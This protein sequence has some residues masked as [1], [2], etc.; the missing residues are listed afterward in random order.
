[1]C[2]I[3]SGTMTLPFLKAPDVLWRAVGLVCLGASL[4]LHHPTA[5]AAEKARS[6]VSAPATEDETARELGRKVIAIQRALENPQAPGSLEAVTALGH[7]SRYY[8]MVRG[9]LSQVL[10]ADSSIRDASKEGTPQKIKERISFVEKA[11]RAIDLE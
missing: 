1:M 4:S 3:S 8:V 5:A 10:S 2:I 11:I 7:D 9:W 6:G